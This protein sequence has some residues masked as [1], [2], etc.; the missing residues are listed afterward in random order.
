MITF[1]EVVSGEESNQGYKREHTCKVLLHSFNLER[2]AVND[3]DCP[4]ERHSYQAC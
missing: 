2:K 1:L 3:I 4:Q